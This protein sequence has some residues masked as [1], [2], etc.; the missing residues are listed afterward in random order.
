MS[1]CYKCGGP[2]Q[3]AA[4]NNKHLWCTICGEE[5]N[6]SGGP[7][8][9]A[10]PKVAVEAVRGE[11]ASPALTPEPE[12]TAPV[13]PPSGEQRTRSFRVTVGGV[14]FTATGKTELSVG[15]SRVV[16]ELLPP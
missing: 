16:I 3:P 2:L 7:L 14:S 13:V 11:P 15:K 5:L 10:K 6:M 4:L 12:G 8:T 1:A 9:D